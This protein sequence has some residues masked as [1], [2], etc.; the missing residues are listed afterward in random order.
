MKTQ[1]F[2]THKFKALKRVLENHENVFEGKAQAIAAKDNFTEMVNQMAALI[3]D[4]TVPLT[5]VYLNRVKARNALIAK[6]GNI[7]QIAIMFASRTNDEVLLNTLKSYNRRYRSVAANE[8]IQFANYLISALNQK[9]DE[10]AE[11]GITAEE[12]AQLQSSID[13]YQQ[14]SDKVAL[15][16]GERKSRRMQINDLIKNSNELLQN[17]IDRFVR[18]HNTSHPDLSFAYGRVRW[19]R[20]RK[21]TGGSLPEDSDISGMVSDAVTGLPI[22]GATLSLIEHAHALNTD[23]EG[24]YLFD[25]LE[26]GEYTITCHATGYKVPEPFVLILSNNDAVIH[27]F[28]LTP[29]VPEA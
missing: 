9:M 23:A 26:P 29:A 2:T 8:M 28:H 13:N 24:Y 14:A 3:T 10:A 4:L 6:L 1:I 20:R 18:F 25:H 15:E 27:N 19:R 17:S 16:I 21:P 11:V 22:A 7:L 12:I 5:S